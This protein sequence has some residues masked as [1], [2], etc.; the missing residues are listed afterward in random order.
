VRI[1]VG[2]RYR[3]EVLTDFPEEE[4][5]WSTA[6]PVYEEL[7]GWQSSTHGLRDYAALPSKAREY[8]ERLADL[9][10]VPFSLVSTGPVRDE[11]ILVSDSALTRWF[12][13]LRSALPAH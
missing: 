8:V 2:Y 7:S 4:R 5:I 11:T 13:A 9:I 6:E 12:P 1:C 3:G 10:G